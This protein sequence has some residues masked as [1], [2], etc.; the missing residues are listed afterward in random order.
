MLISYA[1]FYVQ[2]AIKNIKVTNSF[3]IIF[4]TVFIKNSIYKE[5]KKLNLLSQ[6][7]Y[8]FRTGS[9]LKIDKKEI[10]TI[11]EFPLLR[12]LGCQKCQQRPVLA[13][14]NRGRRG[15]KL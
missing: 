4:P 3:L 10:K 12:N 9:N 5:T 11:A 6:S 7:K 1:I 13:A 15:Q 2:F 14:A 8:Q